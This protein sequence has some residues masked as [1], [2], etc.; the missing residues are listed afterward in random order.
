MQKGSVRVIDQMIVVKR[1]RAAVINTP[2]GSEIRQLVDR[3][4][5]PVELCSLAEETLHAGAAVRRHYHNGTEEIYYI[6]RGA[7]RM[8]VGAETCE[9]AAGDAVYIPRGAEHT[10]ANTGAV[11]MTILLVCGPA[12][13]IADHHMIETEGAGHQDSE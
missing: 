9:V 2:H 10:L 3:T 13:S 8:T 12:Y 4:T 1:E 11:P 7:G 6:T 5:S